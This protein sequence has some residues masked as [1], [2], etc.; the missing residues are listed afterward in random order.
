MS[1]CF[2]QDREEGGERERENPVHVIINRG[3]SKEIDTCLFMNL[4]AMSACYA[5]LEISLFMCWA[6]NKVCP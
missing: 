6:N 1:F 2:D 4:L 3:K 5:A